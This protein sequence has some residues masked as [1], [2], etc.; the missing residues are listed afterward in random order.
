MKI[1]IAISLV[2]LTLVLVG[3]S[4]YTYPTN[5]P[6]TTTTKT[7]ITVLSQ[8]ENETEARLY[9]DNWVSPA[10]INVSNYYAGATAE[11]KIRVHNG[12]DATPQYES[13]SVGTEPNETI[14]PIKLKSPLA[15]GDYA[16]ATVISDNPSDKLIPVAYSSQTKELTISG[17]VPNVTRIITISYIAWTEYKI[18]YSIPSK[19]R[20]GYSMPQIETSG[21][22]VFSDMIPVLA[23]KET[24]EIT[25]TLAMP[26]GTLSVNDKWE[27]WVTVM[28]QGQGNIETRCAVR[29]LISMR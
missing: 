21:W 26:K 7:T 24:R 4:S 25:V 10:E 27:F 23:P 1:A 9:N 11:W 19:L 12:N 28:E 17:F 29:W 3:C 20:Y 14:V 6:A 13:C 16:K 18:D 15:G 8:K 22:V 2:L 5:T